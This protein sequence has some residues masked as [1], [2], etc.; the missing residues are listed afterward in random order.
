AQ[1]EAIVQWDIQGKISIR[2]GEDLFTADLYWQQQKDDLSMRLVAPFS[3]GVTQFTG[4]DNKGYQVL[5]DQ[6]ELIDVDSPESVTE[7]AFGVSLPFSEL[8]SWIKGVPDRDLP[9]W[10]ASFNEE[11]RLQ[12]FQQSGWEIKIL[13]YRKVGNKMLPAKLFLSRLNGD[14]TENKVDVRLILRRWVL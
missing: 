13:K 5:T 11:N 6:G 14:L 3:Q 7:H 4:N 1:L 12:K 9:V 2:S 8:K 10:Q